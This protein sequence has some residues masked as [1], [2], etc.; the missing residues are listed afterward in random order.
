M[1]R[2]TLQNLNY[3]Q[4]FLELST[5]YHLGIDEELFNSIDNNAKSNSNTND[6]DSNNSNNNSSNNNNTAS[7]YSYGTVG[8]SN[9]VNFTISMQSWIGKILK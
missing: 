2:Y 7:S 6:G 1:W 9:Q 4:R 8:C 3:R 5:Y